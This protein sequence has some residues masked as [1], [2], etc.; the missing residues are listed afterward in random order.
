LEGGHVAAEGYLDGE[1]RF[2]VGAGVDGADAGAVLASLGFDDEVIVAPMFLQA[3]VKGRLLGRRAGKH[4]GNV[5]IAM[6]RGVIRKFPVL[7]NILSFL[8]LSQLLTGKIPD[9]STEG[10]LFDKIRGSFL[11]NNGVARTED[12]RIHSEAMGVT[13]VGD[14]DVIQNRCDFKVGVQPFVGLDRVVDQIPVFRHYL[15]GPDRSVLATYFLVKGPMAD[16]KVTPTPFRSLGEGILGIFKR[17][18][19]NPFKEFSPPDLNEP[20]KEESVE[21]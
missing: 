11:L 1:G 7:A 15:A 9:L 13:I 4:S 17:L 8:N 18:L 14:L 10:M 21:R 20:I 3:G 2:W 16:P 6:D 19:E 12:F 5:E